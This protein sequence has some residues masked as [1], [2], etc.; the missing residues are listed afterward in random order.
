MLKLTQYLAIIG[1][2]LSNTISAQHEK[3]ASSHM[4]NQLIKEQAGYADALLANERQIQSIIAR[5][6][7]SKTTEDVL[8]IPVVIHV[9]HLG[10]SIGVGNNISEEQIT[11]G[12]T[13]LNE[14]FRNENGLGLDLKIEF[15]LAVLDPNCA[16]TTGILRVDGSGVS[17]YSTNGVLSS[18]IGA[19]ETAVK[20]LSIWSN[21]DYYNIW[22]V[23]EF[24][25]ND[26]G[27]GTQGFAYFPGAS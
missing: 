23:S 14:G 19:D 5:K 4:Q 6:K 3:C 26:G 27:N 16:S 13:Q 8:T 2:M 24:D 21:T 20:A 7:R 25:G 15:E 9:V 10:E 11:S 22:L 17:G 18:S 12:I 1:L